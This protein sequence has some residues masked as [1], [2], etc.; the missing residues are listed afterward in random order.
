MVAFVSLPAHASQVALYET[1]EVKP[2]SSLVVLGLRLVLSLPNSESPKP[3]HE[4]MYLKSYE[5]SP[6]HSRSMP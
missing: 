3:L 6:Y 1:G 4:G 5:G 2:E